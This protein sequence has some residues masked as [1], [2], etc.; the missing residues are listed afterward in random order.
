VKFE[1]K[2]NKV[3]F[4]SKYTKMI[5]LYSYMLREI[6]IKCLYIYIYILDWTVQTIKMSGCTV[7]EKH[8]V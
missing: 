6:K 3:K 5:S 4:G 7:C 1:N 8:V 2:N